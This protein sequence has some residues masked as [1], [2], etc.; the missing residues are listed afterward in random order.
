MVLAIFLVPE[1]G[2]DTRL[3]AIALKVGGSVAWRPKLRGSASMHKND[4]W[5][6]Q[7]ARRYI[8]REASGTYANPGFVAP[9]NGGK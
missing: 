1:A 9:R 5:Q 8:P 6:Q 3:D 7:T 2:V 4:A